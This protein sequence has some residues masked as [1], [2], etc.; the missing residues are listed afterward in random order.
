MKSETATRGSSGSGSS[1]HLTSELTALFSE[2]SGLGAADLAPETTFMELGLDSLFLTQASQVL[3]KRFGVKIAFR[4]LMQDL[5][6][7]SALAAFLSAKLPSAGDARPAP[8]PTTA[9][10]VETTVTVKAPQPVA[11]QPSG[12]P[13]STPV[14]TASRPSALTLTNESLT[15]APGDDPVIERVIAQQMAIMQQQ[16][17]LL[18]GRA[19]ADRSLGAPARREPEPASPPSAPAPALAKPKGKK[20]EAAAD[21]KRFGPFKGIELGP[22]GGLTPRQEKSLNELIERYNRRT[23]SSKTYAQKHRPYFCDPRAAGNF[24]LQWKQMVYPIVCARSKGSKIWDI[25]G[26]EYVDVTLGFGA[27]YFGHSPD[28]VVKALEEQLEKGFEIGPQSP[29]AGEAADLFCRMTRMERATFCN[30]G[31]EAVMAAIRIA[32]TVTARDTIVYFSGDYHGIFDEVLGRPATIEGKPGASPIAPGIPPLPNVLILEYG[33]PA[34]LETIRERAADIAAV[35]VEPVQSRHPDLQPREFLH[36]LRKLTEELDMALIFDEVVTGFRAA[37]GGAQ[38]YFGVQA[39]LA[40]YGKVIGGGMPVGILAGKRRFMDALDGGM[41]DFADGSY[42]EVGVTFFAGTFVRHPL[43][44][45]AV[46]ASLRY[47][48]Q[49]GPELQRRTTEK[50]AKL[51]RRLNDYFTSIEVPIRIQSFS[52]VFYYDFHPDLKYASLLF[53]HLRDRGI[54]V[55]EGRVAQI[56]TAHTEE[57]LEKIFQAFKSSV[58]E[59][60][61]GGFLP[62]RDPDPGAKAGV[63]PASAPGRVAAASGEASL[64]PGAVPLTEAQ[65]E[66]WIAAQMGEDAN[67]AYNESSSLRFSGP[68]DV[69][70]FRKA[71]QQFVD[72]HDALRSRFGA[73]GDYQAFLD[74]EIVF[75]REWDLTGVSGDQQAAQIESI[76]ADDMATPFD[77]VRGPMFRMQ[78]LKL[79]S[80]QHQFLFTTHHA[81]CDGWSFGVVFHEIAQFYT[82]LM[83]GQSLT[84]PPAMQFREFTAWARE[85]Q[86]SEEVRQAE[87]FWIKQFEGDSIPVLDLP[88]DRPRP[89]VKTYVG[90]FLVRRCNPDLFRDLKKT[91]GQMGNT[92]FSTLFAAFTTLVHQLSGQDDIVVGI[93]AAGQTIVGSNDLVGHCLN[94]LPVRSA[95]DGAKPFAEYAAQVKTEVLDA[96]EHQNYTYGTLLGKLKIERDPSRLPLLSV[97]FNIDRRGLD[98]LNFFSLKTE[99]M[100]NAKQFVNFD[101]FFNLVQGDHTLD[102]ECEY[103]TDLF[104]R[105]TVERWLGHFETLMARIVQNPKQ[106][107]GSMS[108]LNPAEREQL[109]VDWNRTQR[110]YPKGSTI[111]G[112]I[113]A[114][115]L[116][117]PQAIAAIHDNQELTYEELNRRANHF[118]RQLQQDGARPDSLVALCVE[119]NLDL[120]IGTLAILKSGAAYVPLD[121]AY[122]RERLA[123]YLQDSGA[124]IILTQRK[125]A[126][127]LPPH[128]AKVLFLDEPVPPGSI[129]NALGGASESHLAYV[130]YTSGS[131]GQPKGVAIEHRQAANFI[132]WGKEAFSDEEMAGVL[133]STSICFDLSVFELFVTLSRGG[134][135]L[136]AENALQLSLLPA[137]D[138]VTLINTVPSA[139]AELV[140]EQS[141]PSSTQVVNLAGEILATPLVDRI[142][143]LPHIRKVYDLYG[144]TETTTYS[145]WTLRRTGERATIGRP[146]ANTQVYVVDAELR[147]VP[148]GVTG[149]L[150]IAGDGVARGYLHR[151]DQTELRFIPNPFA[152]AGARAYRTGD[153]ARYREDGELELVGRM[154]NQVKLR[155]FRIELGEIDSLIRQDPE[156]MESAVIVREDEPGQKRILAYVSARSGAGTPNAR[157]AAQ[158]LEQLWQSRWETLF[159]RAV[160]EVKGKSKK[161]E[162]VDALI[163]GWTGLENPEFQTAEWV[164]TT[165]ARVR[166]LAPRRIFE[167]GCGSGQL[168]LR[169]APETES[170]WASDPSPSAIEMIDLEIQSRGLKHVH[171]SRGTADSLEGAPHGGFDLFILNSVSQHFPDTDHF[172]R[173]I[174]GAL[175]LL[176]PGGR[177]FIGDV[178]SH[179]LLECFHTAATLKSAPAELTVDDVRRRVWHQASHELE[180]VV[181]PEFFE[182]LPRLLPQITAVDVQLKRGRQLSETTQYHYDIVLHTSSEVEQLPVT[183]WHDWSDEGLSLD[184]ARLLLGRTSAAPVGFRHVPNAR[185][186][187]DVHMWRCLK[188]AP[189]EQTV[190]QHLEKTPTEHLGV[191]P[192]A[193]WALAEDLQLQLDIRPG[194]A[195]RPG[196]MDFV[197]SQPPQAGRTVLP[198][199]REASAGGGSAVNLQSC[200]NNPARNL[201]ELQLAKRL[202]ESLATKL[203][204]FMV[205]SA[206]VVL[207]GMPRTPNGKINRRA[208]PRP[209]LDPGSQAHEFVAPSNPLEEKLAA[210]WKDVLGLSKVSVRDN[211]FELGGDSLLSFRVASRASQIGLP[212]TPRMFFSYKTI[213]GLV[214]AA[215]KSVSE[216]GPT[217]KQ[218]VRRVSREG[219][220]QKLSS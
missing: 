147:P 158:E 168:L 70:K 182:A 218:G 69:G 81:V 47:L 102:L 216:G 71:L 110:A 10:P 76:I 188:E 75:L 15:A 2:L 211:F 89:P 91:S 65:K 37:P 200:S 6:S 95:V 138:Q 159:S 202:K 51:V 39:D 130:I 122:P 197:F 3:Q 41:W 113:E 165:A 52:S 78:L 109:L 142:Y 163:A 20:A 207:R 174:Q 79:G 166:A 131:T 156:V 32:R 61:A 125:L 62:V 133:A 45:A 5:A 179:S 169:L 19:A 143:G 106:P 87:A 137:R 57:D 144:P 155:G 141:I 199:F 204:E 11:P 80:E 185:L 132:H 173:V 194:G 189:P 195:D 13:A 128:R 74:Q 160:E 139:I 214:Q 217:L 82:A 153:L 66:I 27:N 31:S 59:M 220:K 58:E 124:P 145:T 183:E 29:L 219:R 105:S 103:N 17:D 120:V 77:L 205:P 97:L 21:L 151:A 152:E 99:L 55:W 150:L 116:R 111:H 107:L 115:T 112:L 22:K 201:G 96:Y 180:L 25:D 134:K 72:R 92:L 34:S 117:T 68:L 209:A 42:P 190:Q 86:D 162:T 135:V 186:S 7:I 101:L 140:Q 208:L 177:L 73:G 104:N 49:A 127:S 1:A 93:P 192:E 64:P 90:S 126:S 108:L 100:T 18:R 40:T 181:D 46:N 129:A 50:T 212:L 14:P 161:P 149:E 28:F 118:A 146:L 56:C 148:I 8:A 157:S 121:P 36:Q 164:E 193:L 53:Y 9:P 184:R 83:Q 4:D 88:Y 123:S 171:L 196:L 206:I 172:I 136:I 210:I 48:E 63:S 187:R 16:L 94:F 54:H 35:M 60:Q 191:D 33:N 67:C 215:Q 85:Q 175:K 114:Q 24:R 119:R 178:H 84:L 43:V 176:A 12:P 30:T 170:Y 203:P 154:D 38:E 98:R 213:E 198:A 167:A 26:N 23:P 44:L